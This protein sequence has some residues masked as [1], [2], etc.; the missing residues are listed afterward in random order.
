MISRLR[1]GILSCIGLIFIS[2]IRGIALI[3]SFRPDNFIIYSL[4]IQVGFLWFSVSLWIVLQYDLVK[5]NSLTHL[6]KPM[7]WL[8]RNIAYFSSVGLIMTFFP[9]KELYFLRFLL[10]MFL[11]INYISVYVRIYNLDKDDLE[12]IDDLHN[13][14]I[15]IIA[16]SITFIIVTILNVLKWRI[17][18]DY[19]FFF[20][21]ALPI[22]FLLRFLWREKK[23]IENKLKSNLLKYS[24]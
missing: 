17:E 5:L 11:I 7:D 22:L 9:T 16:I 4:I 10:G 21:N 13:Y 14:I 19:L 20:L 8:I 1:S 18:L 15:S 2:L 12:F 24:G 3:P 23:D 6:R